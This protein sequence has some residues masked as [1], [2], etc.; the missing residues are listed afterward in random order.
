MTKRPNTGPCLGRSSAAPILMGAAVLLASGSAFAI[1]A[2]SGEGPQAVA[3]LWQE[4]RGLKRAKHY[5]S[6]QAKLDEILAI[7]PHHP[8]AW[9]WRST[10]E[11]WILDREVRLT[12]KVDDALDD[13]M[14][15]MHEEDVEEIVEL[16]GKKKH[17]D[18]GTMDF[19]RS[20]F[21]RSR[22]IRP[23][24]TLNSVQ[25]HDNTAVF[26]AQI[27]ITARAKGSTEF[28]TVLDHSWNCQLVGD[29][30]TCPFP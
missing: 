22:A 12:A 24:Y 21:K 16:W 18:P 14:D 6:L 13:L 7:D 4:A 8:Q 25:V 26:S 30:F 10:S 1:N 23:T 29:R 3:D 17:M 9:E 5:H 19:F 11:R 2:S 28:E 20:L 27:V 15:A